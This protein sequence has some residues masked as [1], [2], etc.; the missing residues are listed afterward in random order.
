MR[1]HLFRL[2]CT[3]VPLLLCACASPTSK[4]PQPAG[5][6][7]LIGVAGPMSGDLAVFGQQLKRGAQQAVADL[8]MKGGVLGKKVRL[9]VGDDQCDPK[10]AA[11]VANDLAKQGAVFVAGHFCSGSSIPASAVYAQAAVL[12]ITPASTNP[13]LTEGAAAN[14]VKTLFRTCGNDNMQGTFAGKWM[15]ENYAGKQV[16]V[17]DDTS[18]YGKG[19]A[20]ETER[21]M[22]ANG[23]K[24]ALRDSYTQKQKDFST[25]IARLQTAKI[26]MVYVGGYHNDI[27]LLVRQ[28]RAQGFAGDFAAAD[29]LNTSEFWSIAGTAGDGVRFTDASSQINFVSAKSVVKEFRADNYEPE[30]YTLSA[31]AAVQAWAAGAAIANATAA[32]KV[33]DALH[34]NVI[35]TVIGDL[36]WDDKGDLTRAEYAWF[37]WHDGQITEEP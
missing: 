9:A 10:Q 2:A 13:K 36:S 5:N 16:A 22:E 30:G 4:Q 35:P 34:H 31:Y 8:N 29:A 37:V 26:D 15:A 14:G 32:G 12:Q 11:S 23:L 28:A 27:G 17:L 20:D 24:A 6:E 21:S 7:I 33:A 3:A 25:L 18:S 1:T 19:V